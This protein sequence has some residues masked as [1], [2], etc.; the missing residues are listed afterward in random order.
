MFL[1]ADWQKISLPWVKYTVGNNNL[2]TEIVLMCQMVV[3]G[4]K[5]R[6][7]PM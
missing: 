2:W 1:S 5:G 7:N 6:F 4:N 3:K